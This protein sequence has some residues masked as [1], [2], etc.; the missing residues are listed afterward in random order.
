MSFT[1][2]IGKSVSSMAKISSALN[3]LTVFPEVLHNSEFYSST[4]ISARKQAGKRQLLW[5]A[6]HYHDG[7]ASSMWEKKKYVKAKEKLLDN[8]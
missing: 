4:N 5:F 2:G 7:R 8:E 6:R 1:V 3:F